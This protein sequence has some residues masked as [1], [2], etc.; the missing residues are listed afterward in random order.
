MAQQRLYL[1]LT[2]K[3]IVL[4]FAPAVFTVVGLVITVKIQPLQTHVLVKTGV[5]EQKFNQLKQI[6]EDTKSEVGELRADFKRFAEDIP[7]TYLTIREADRRFDQQEALYNSWLN[8]RRSL[9]DSR[10]GVARLNF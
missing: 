8:R 1:G 6:A 3:E 9:L 5:D 2:L 7:K 10:K 4:V